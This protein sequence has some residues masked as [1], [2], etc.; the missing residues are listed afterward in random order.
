[1]MKPKQRCI[2]LSRVTYRYAV[3][4]PAHRCR[5]G[6]RRVAAPGTVPGGLTIQRAHSNAFVLFAAGLEAL[7]KVVEEQVD[8]RSRVA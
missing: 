7:A 3:S 5:V 4:P 1:M 6:S 2:E 8:V